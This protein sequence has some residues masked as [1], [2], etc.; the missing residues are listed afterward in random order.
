MLVLVLSSSSSSLL[1][2]LI[3]LFLLFSLLSLLPL[4]LLSSLVPLTLLFI[5]GGPGH[6][7]PVR[8]NGL[9]R[10]RDQEARQLPAI[11]TLIIPPSL[12]QPR[13]EDRAGPWHTAAQPFLPH[14]HQQQGSEISTILTP[15]TRDLLRDKK[16]PSFSRRPGGGVHEWHLLMLFILV[17]TFSDL[18]C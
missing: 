18:G 12:Q 10:Q 11:Q 2:L 3:L 14:P 8:R 17:C 1:L 16:L 4:L 9:L 7:G 15:P 5:V 6:P 13:L